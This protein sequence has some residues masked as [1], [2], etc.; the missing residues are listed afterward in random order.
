[1]SQGTG[2][3]TYRQ[4]TVK[5]Y[6]DSEIDRKLKEE[7]VKNPAKAWGIDQARTFTASAYTS[8]DATLEDV[9]RKLVKAASRNGLRDA[10]S[11]M[12]QANWQEGGNEGSYFTGTVTVVT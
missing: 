10:T 9:V 7:K 12:L 8:D 11:V 2:T 5:E 1:M 6:I 3:A 4:P